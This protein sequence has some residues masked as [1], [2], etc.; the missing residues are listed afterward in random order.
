[1]LMA[2]GDLLPPPKDPFSMPLP[3]TTTAED[4]E[5]PRQ[6]LEAQRQR[7]LVERQKFRVEQDTTRA[8]SLHH[9][10]HTH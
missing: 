8:L 10:R 2:T 7:E 9:Q 3:A 5:M 6:T 1:M 4:I